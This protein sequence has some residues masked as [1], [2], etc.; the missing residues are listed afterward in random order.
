M[1]N[2]TG[3]DLKPTEI[4]TGKEYEAYSYRWIILILF[5]LSNA[6]NG[7]Q[8]IQ[9]STINDLV[10]RYYGVPSWAVDWTSMI[11]LILY[12]PFMFP[13]AV[14]AQ[15]KVKNSLVLHIT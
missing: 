14:L 7:Y 2:L 12:V 6:T 5:A 8:W 13:A 4:T 3:S 10:Q 11:C 1:S 9:Y 15:E